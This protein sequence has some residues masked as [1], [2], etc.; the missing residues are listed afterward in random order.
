MNQFKTNQ[1]ILDK[2]FDA[3]RKR[4]YLNGQLTVLHCHH[5]STLYTQLAIDAGETE[6]LTSV[7]FNTFYK[8][9]YDY[10][11]N[12]EI[13]STDEKIDIASQYFS[14]FG[15]GKMEINYFG[16]VSGEVV[17]TSSHLDN[18]WIKKWGNSDKPVNYLAAGY[19]KAMFSVIN[20]N[21]VD[22]YKVKEIKSIA[23][24]DTFSLFQVYA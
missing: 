5:Y 24:G 16:D 20:E 22:N 19:I 17:L 3:A 18:G 15:L 10:F 13:Q 7:S 12:N 23:M 11:K 6:L 21:P 4:H 8:V 9:L 14:A 1:L 2:K